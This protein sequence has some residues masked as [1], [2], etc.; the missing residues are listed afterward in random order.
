[1]DIPISIL[2]V[3]VFCAEQYKSEDFGG[4]AL[5]RLFLAL[6]TSDLTLDRRHSM[7]DGRGSSG[8]VSIRC[9]SRHRRG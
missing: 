9:W 3:E 7:A 1:M 6:V 4:D 8:A 5:L 2:G